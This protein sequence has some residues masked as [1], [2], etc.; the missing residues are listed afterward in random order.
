MR[1]NASHR[2]PE[3]SPPA[4]AKSVPPTDPDELAPI[5]AAV[6]RQ[7]YPG[8]EVTT[9][10][11]FYRDRRGL[12]YALSWPAAWLR[13][14]GLTCSPARYR[15]MIA[16]RLEAI[17]THGDP[18]KF[19]PPGRACAAYFPAYLLKCLQDWFLHHGDDLYDELKHVR[20]ALDQVLASPRF[21]A[22]VQRDAHY[23]DILAAAHRLTQ[24]PRT[25]PEKSDSGQLSLF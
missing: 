10:A 19:A 2:H 14:R 22:Q 11:R 8:S 16:E 18:A 6:Q 4:A 7:F 17:A 15:S 13:H 1:V 5:L 20:N 9:R 12:L 3:G 21:A 23:L 24:P 25:R